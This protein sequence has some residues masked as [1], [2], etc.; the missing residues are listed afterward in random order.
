MENELF[1]RQ[2][3]ISLMR[4]FTLIELLVVIAVI[5]ILASLMLPALNRA[6]EVARGVTCMNNLKQLLLVN[7]QYGTDY[8]GMIIV[9][10]NGA[11]GYGYLTWREILESADYIKNRSIVLCP[12]A[13]PRNWDKD[14][15]N[16]IYAG[17]RQSTFTATY[18]PDNALL[19]VKD[20]AGTADALNVLY[21][22]R[23]RRASG[24]VYYMDSW[25]KV[26]KNQIWTI[27]PSG[28]SNNRVAAHHV[29]KANIG[30]MD[31]HVEG[32]RG[33]AMT[34]YGIMAHCIDGK[35]VVY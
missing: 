8:D 27:A 31:G 13:A 22:K 2:R 29:G 3:K 19:S 21:M 33:R 12:A 5:A 23:L 10:T 9:R 6:R 35:E 1:E 15:P 24:F 32:L 14:N 16:N 28:S 26:N 11:V 7:H 4:N 30:F 25:H 17:R 20:S 18:D 34:A